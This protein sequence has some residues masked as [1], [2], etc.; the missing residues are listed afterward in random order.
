MSLY[1]LPVVGRSG[2]GNMLFP[3]A[4]AEIFA[5]TYHASVLA[6]NWGWLRLGPYLRGEPEKRNYRGMFDAP[7]FVRGVARW[8]IIVSAESTDETAF[9]PATIG[10]VRRR[11]S[12]VVFH[13]FQGAFK[14]LLPER[15]F[16][17]Q[18]LLSITP[19]KTREETQCDA[20]F[21]GVHVRR[22][23]IT[24]SGLDPEQLAKVWQFT[25]ISWFIDMVKCIRRKREFA[26][27][28]IIIFTDGSDDEVGDLLKFNNVRMHPRATALADMWTLSKADL[29][30]AGGASTFAHWANFL[31]DMPSIFQTGKL[32]SMTRFGIQFE[33]DERAEIPDE[34]FEVIRERRAKI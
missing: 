30:I 6:P 32:S 7:H 28:P 9:D 10:Q 4:R 16:V 8:L 29:L 34:A 24:R 12:A 18:Q 14:P 25:P 26:D 5:R 13:G 3:W 20:H 21:I 27:I 19:E 2:L 33:L 31:G 15:A 23:D 17:R 1:A 11:P 22:G